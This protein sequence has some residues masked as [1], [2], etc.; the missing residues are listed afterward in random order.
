[1]SAKKSSK[2]QKE[3]SNP[4]HVKL[5]FEEA[6]TSKKAVLS[7]EM[8]LLEAAKNIETYKLL[9][10]KELTLKENLKKK[11]KEARSSFKKLKAALPE[12]EMPKSVKKT[13]SETH[14]SPHSTKGK[15][16]EVEEQLL[17]IQK[18]LDALQNEKFN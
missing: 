11:S 6:I 3:N 5:D 12:P 7:M 18:R 14:I 17:E 10:M 16:G 1:M 9:R 15:K 13:E 8:W 2:T 4:V